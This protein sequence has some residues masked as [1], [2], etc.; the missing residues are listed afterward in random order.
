MG[1]GALHD[2]AD[3]PTP[4]IFVNRLGDIWTPC[5]NLNTDERRFG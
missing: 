1:L 2:L 3:V 4:L 5:S